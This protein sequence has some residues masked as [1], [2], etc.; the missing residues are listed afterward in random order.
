MNWIFYTQIASIVILT[1]GLFFNS[2]K[3]KLSFIIIAVS[4]AIT[5]FS[6][7]AEWWAISFAVLIILHVIVNY[8]KRN[9]S[10]NTI[11]ILEV[12]VNDAY[13]HEFF[14]YYSK[15]LYQYFP[16]YE[17]NSSHSVNLLIR[18]MNIAGILILKQE[19][20][21]AYIEMDFI[22]PEFRDFTI[23]NY[24]YN[25]NTGFFKKRGINK[26]MAKSYHY[27][28]SKYLLKMGFKQGLIDGELYFVKNID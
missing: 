20:D 25:Q 7:N 21:I 28:H 26:L 4:A 2:S 27:K 13:V 3:L 18:D 16:I 17:T 22:K 12:G 19:K 24:I 11:N 14:K 1:I 8:I 6:F 23:G 5:V 10:Y 9:K 15:S